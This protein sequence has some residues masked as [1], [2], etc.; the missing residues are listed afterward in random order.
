MRRPGH[1]LTGPVSNDMYGMQC[2]SSGKVLHMEVVPNA[3]CSSTVGHIFLDFV[4]KYGMI[5]EELNVDGGSET[6]KMYTCHDALWYVKVQY[7]I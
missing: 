2:H 6:G 3:Y 4:K 1:H 7:L 5:P